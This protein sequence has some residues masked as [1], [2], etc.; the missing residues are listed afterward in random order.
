MY[1]RTSVPGVGCWCRVGT[2]HAI[3]TEDFGR[4]RLT[5]LHHCVG[6]RTMYI[7]YTYGLAADPS[8]EEVHTEFS[9]FHDSYR[10]EYRHSVHIITTLHNTKSCVIAFYGFQIHAQ[11]AAVGQ[12]CKCFSNCSTVQVEYQS[13]APHNST[14]CTYFPGVG[15]AGCAGRAGAGRYSPNDH[16][17]P[18]LC[19]LSH[20]H[21]IHSLTC[22]YSSISSSYS[23]D[24]DLSV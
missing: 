4:F 12:H 21:H 13:I 23:S 22:A 7:T 5:G 3:H 17:V 8:A 11:D 18:L 16:L 9:S 24:S 15:L 1:H 20:P 6:I 10:G 14:N 2:K 19:P